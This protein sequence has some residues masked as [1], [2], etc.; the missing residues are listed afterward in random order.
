VSEALYLSD[1]EGNGIE[2][3]ADR[4]RQEWRWSGE[5]VQME[6]RA[7]DV[8][9][10]VAAGGEAVPEEARVPEGTRIGHLHL[11][12]G[13]LPEAERF[14][15]GALGLAITC[16][17]PGALFYA[18]GRYHH[19]LA[20]NTWQSRNSPK[21]SGTT[22]GL[23]SFELLVSDGA[24]FEAAAERLISLGGRRTAEAIEACD[25]WG[26]LVILKRA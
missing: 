8:A 16:R 9:G 1:P 17:Y 3:Y 24:A 18:T 5:E 12:V 11:R 15:A 19:H 25:P 6:T 21:R 10:L 22:T 2:V 20:T 7:L 23:A 4:P 14:Y 13:S 26:S